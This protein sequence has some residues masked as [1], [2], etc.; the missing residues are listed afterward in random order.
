MDTISSTAQTL[1]A[2][3][4][5]YE[6]QPKKRKGALRGAF[7]VACLKEQFSLKSL[8]RRYRIAA[9]MPPCQGGDTGSTPVTCSKL[10]EDESILLLQENETPRMGCF[11]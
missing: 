11:T 1:Y 2:V 9:I 7:F 3:Q 10:V 4:P 6:V 5:L 8:L